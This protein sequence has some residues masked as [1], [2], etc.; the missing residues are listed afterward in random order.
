MIVHKFPSSADMT[1]LANPARPLTATMRALM[2]PIRSLVI[3]T[4]P[5]LVTTM[6]LVT[7]AISRVLWVSPNQVLAL[8]NTKNLSVVDKCEHH[9]CELPMKTRTGL[10]LLRCPRF[11][12]RTVES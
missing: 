8:V 6:S 2:T 1:F 3:T 11:K 5:L 12:S 4:G 10:H 9:L 7:P